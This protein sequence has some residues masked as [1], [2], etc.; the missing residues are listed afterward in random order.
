MVDVVVHLHDRPILST[1][2]TVPP[3]SAHVQLGDV[4]QTHDPVELR[5]RV[6]QHDGVVTVLMKLPMQGFA[7]AP[8]QYDRGGLWW[9]GA[10]HMAGRD[11]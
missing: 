5:G 2:C 6:R 4:P 7:Y 9:R 1:K 10:P 3:R 8:L 11:Q